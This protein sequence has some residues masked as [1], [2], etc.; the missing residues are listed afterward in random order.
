MNSKD[1]KCVNLTNLCLIHKDVLIID[2]KIYFARFGFIIK[3]GFFS[4]VGFTTNN[5]RQYPYKSRTV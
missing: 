4:V 3:F 2:I 5:I 1:Q